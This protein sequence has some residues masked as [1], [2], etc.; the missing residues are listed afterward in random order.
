MTSLFCLFFLQYKAWHIPKRLDGIKPR[1]VIEMSFVKTPVS[2]GPSSV[3]KKRKNTS[4][5]HQKLYKPF[6]GSL[7]DLSIPGSLGPVL[8]KV[9]PQPGFIRLWPAENE[10]IPMT[11]SAFGPVPKGSVLSY[12]HPPRPSSSAT[13]HITNAPDVPWFDM[14]VL[15]SMTTVLPER[16]DLFH[17]SLLM[18]PSKV[19]DIASATVHFF[20]IAW[21]NSC[22]KEQD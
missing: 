14:P 5:V 9:N 13:R 16:Q 3:R 20:G 10:E 15:P 2:S 22:F 6:K 19:I 18:T 12:H 21:L 8:F 7:S 17:Q 1:S 4:G 11:Q